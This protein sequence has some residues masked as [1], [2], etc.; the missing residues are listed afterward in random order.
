M[1]TQRRRIKWRKVSTWIA[2]GINFIGLVFLGF[3]TFRSVVGKDKIEIRAYD[4][5]SL[6]LSNEKIVVG[7]CISFKNHGKST[8][9][10]SSLEAFI[11]STSVDS[12]IPVCIQ[13]KVYRS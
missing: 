12:R 13:T 8:G 4:Y 10:I 1:V 5:V 2:I 9:V 7:P 6:W 11:V 3:T